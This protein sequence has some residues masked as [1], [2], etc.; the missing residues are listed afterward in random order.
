MLVQEVKMGLSSICPQAPEQGQEWLDLG[1]I[2][3]NEPPIPRDAF[4]KHTAALGGYRGKVAHGRQMGLALGSCCLEEK[5]ECFCSSALQGTTAVRCLSL[6]LAVV[7]PPGRKI[8]VRRRKERAWC[9]EL[10]AM[11]HSSLTSPFSCATG[12][13]GVICMLWLCCH[14]HM[15][16]ICP[17]VTFS[18]CPDGAKSSLA[19]SQLRYE[20]GM[21]AWWQTLKLECLWGHR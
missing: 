12:A 14:L 16:D 18:L 3:S 13:R 19:L 4:M 9:Q 15:G 20:M 10:L 7:G 11:G 2:E 5:Q 21:P 8:S 17:S 1:F 6:A